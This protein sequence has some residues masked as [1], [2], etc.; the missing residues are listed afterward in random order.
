LF[1][2]SYC[3]C[4]ECFLIFIHNHPNSSHS[5][6]L[7]PHTH[8]P[9]PS[10]T[11][12]SHPFSTYPH[13][14]LSLSST[15]LQLLLLLSLLFSTMSLLCSAMCAARSI[16]SVSSS[17]SFPSTSSFT[18]L[19]SPGGSSPSPTA[20]AA[21]S[22]SSS[23]GRLLI[24]ANR[25][26]VSMSVKPAAGDSGKS[27]ISFSS[28]TGGLVS[29]LAGSGMESFW[30]G[31]PGGEVKSK[32]DRAVVVD[33]L[34][35]LGSIPVFLSSELCDL[36]YNGFCNDLLWPLFHYIPLPIDAIKAHDKQFRAYQKANAEFAKVVLDEWE[37]GDVVW[38]HDYHLMLLPALLRHA[39]PGMKIGFFF[40]TPFPSSE[41]YRV[42]PS[43][44]E[45]L[46]G[47]LSSNLLGFHTHDYSRHFQSAATRIIGATC[48]NEHVTLNGAVSSLG[49]FPIGIDPTRFVDALKTEGVQKHL[50]GFRRQ[51]AGKRV[52][53]GID[54]LDYI[55]G[56]AHKLHALE[57][58]FDRNP[59]FVG[60]VVLVQIAIPSRTDVVEY[61]KLK[62]SMHELV[63]RINGRF[64][65]V[66]SVPIHY[67]DQSIPF[68]N[69]CALYHMADCMIITSI[70]DGMNLVAYEYIACQ[71]DS[72][73][74]LILSEFA[75]AAQS[76]GAGALQV[77]P[78]NISEVADAIHKALTMKEAE[79]KER[80]DYWSDIDT[81]TQAHT[82][83]P[84]LVSDSVLALVCC[85]LFV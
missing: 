78:W 11:T 28:S 57:L 6:P 63:G 45:L 58:F 1:V 82:T 10:H 41:I 71:N 37:E 54:R 72:N 9:S 84:A 47:V 16:P 42:I 26:P 20:K 61:Q 75:G 80:T 5:S 29:A 70:R 38:V 18:D 53:L 55:K 66:S 8:S 22:S 12:L 56:I 79:R 3:C 7:H 13:L 81:Y 69:M 62:T 30:I 33:K 85:V 4:E 83:Q 21:S 43:R 19:A 59:S 73:G 27:D 48:S 31:W 64:G 52:L 50:A 77:N 68:N 25:L 32:E 49:T 40:H 14:T 2:C 46:Y 17:S 35:A 44:D 36:F 67:L 76:L 34:K 39:K 15:P 23:S 65:S 51:F 74:V 60:E 24:V